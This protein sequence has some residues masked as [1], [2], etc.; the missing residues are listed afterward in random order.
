[1]NAVATGDRTFLVVRVGLLA[2]IVMASLLLVSSAGR[3][4]SGALDVTGGPPPAS[5]THDLGAATV[6][7]LSSACPLWSARGSGL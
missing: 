7:A 6:D 4:P 3:A 1:M 2:L 5:A